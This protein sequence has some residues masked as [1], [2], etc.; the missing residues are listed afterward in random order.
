MLYAPLDL[1]DGGHALIT[2][3]GQAIFNA[4]PDVV[5]HGNGNG[6]GRVNGAHDRL[7]G[8]DRTVWHAASKFH[9]IG[10]MPPGHAA[11][12]THVAEVQRALVQSVAHNVFDGFQLMDMSQHEKWL[13]AVFAKKTQVGFIE[14]RTGFQVHVTERGQHRRMSHR[15]AFNILRRQQLGDVHLAGVNGDSH[16][17][18][19]GFKH[20]QGVARI[21]AWPLGNTARFRCEGDGA[22]H[23]QNH[24]RHRFT[25]AMQHFVEHRHALGALAV[26]LAYMHMQQRGA[27]VVAINSL[28]HLLVH[29]YRNILR[30]VGRHPFRAVGRNRDDQLVLVFR[31]QRV[32]GIK[33]GGDLG[34]RYRKK[35]SRW[36]ALGR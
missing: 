21:I 32:M 33:H 24:F 27:G 28:L 19:L 3:P 11:T 29:A 26:S 36:F 25:Q 35:F 17:I 30:K 12:N 5:P 1:L 10:R 2:R 8:E 20:R 4:N 31:E 6:I 34:M 13:D 15:R 14:A 18:R 9:Q 16:L 23:L 22:A 7:V